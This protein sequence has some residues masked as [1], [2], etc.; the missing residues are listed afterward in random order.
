MFVTTRDRIDG[1]TV[2]RELG[3][4]TGST[5]R[6]RIF[7]RDFLAG[8][9]NFLGLEV[10]EYTEMMQQAREEAMDR[11]VEEGFKERA[12]AILNVRFMTSPTSMRTSE[13][14]VYGTAVR[15]K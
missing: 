13:I 3:I 10:K 8:I 11:M 7:Y 12:D 4:V 15:L 5:V 2:V 14:L 6:S 1:K 9:R